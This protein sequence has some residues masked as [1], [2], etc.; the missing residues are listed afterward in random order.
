MSRTS[1]YQFV[2]G[3][4]TELTSE[5]LLASGEDKDSPLLGGGSFVASGEDEDGP[6][7]LVASGEGR[8]FRG[9]TCPVVHI[10]EPIFFSGFDILGFF[11]LTG[12]FSV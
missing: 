1:L 7:S 12:R 3:T 5:D 4:G 10:I 9:V 8:S 2:T 11:V 6:S